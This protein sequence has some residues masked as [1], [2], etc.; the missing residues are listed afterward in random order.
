MKVI[1]KKDVANVGGKGH[2]ADLAN[3]FAHHLI[4]RGVAELAT[5][6]KV[7][8][9]EKVVEARRAE[10]ER[11]REALESGIAKLDGPL[12]IHANANEKEHLFE[13]VSAETIAAH[14][15]DVVG[16]AVD[17]GAIVIAEPIKTLGEHT[18][19][20]AVGGEKTPVVLTVQSN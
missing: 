5:P 17:A 18:V 15:K 10:L 20:V 14:L 11:E 8:R 2:V 7:A 19:H 4:A 1:L 6:G 16:V 3:G 12:T 9:A 13:A